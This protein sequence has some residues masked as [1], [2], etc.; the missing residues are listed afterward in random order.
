MSRWTARSWTI[1]WKTRRAGG[2]SISSPSPS[3]SPSSLSL[4]VERNCEGAF[5]AS[6]GPTGLVQCDFFIR[7]LARSRLVTAIYLFNVNLITPRARSSLVT[8][9]YLRRLWKSSSRGNIACTVAAGGGNTNSVMEKR[10]P[11]P[12]FFAIFLFFFKNH[13]FAWKMCRWISTTK[14]PVDSARLFA[15]VI[16]SLSHWESQN[17]IDVRLGNVFSIIVFLLSLGVPDVQNYCHLLHIFCGLI[18]ETSISSKH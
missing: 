17:L 16:I 12:P 4:Q 3:S 6:Y 18:L 5:Q 15:S 8:S 7:A 9:L 11:V 10:F 1:C 13:R 14:R 2:L